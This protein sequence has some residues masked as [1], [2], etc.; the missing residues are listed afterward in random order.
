MGGR[1]LASFGPIAV[2]ASVALSAQT[3]QPAQTFRSGIDLIEVDVGVIDDDSRPIGDLQATDFSVSV[4][5]EPRRVVQAQF[6]SLRPPVRDDLPAES[7]AQ[8]A[9]YT[10]NTDAA[11]GRLIVIAVDEESIAFG[12]GR[13]VMRAAGAFVDSLGP[14]DR[15]ALLAVPQPGVYIDF[16]SNHARVRQAVD[17]MAGLG[18]PPQVT[19]NIS[20]FEAYRIAEYNDG[21]VEN[22]VV[23]RVCSAGFEGLVCR[24]RMQAESRQIVQE[25]RRRADNTRR[26]VESILGAMREVEGPKALVWISGGFVIDNGSTSL[27]ELEALAAESR[28]TLYVFML[29]E[30]LIDMSQRELAPTPRQDRRMKEEG[31]LAAAAFTGGSLVRAHYNPGPLFERLE[32]EL[33]GYYLL[34]VES[35]AGDRDGE[36]H[37][38]DVAVRRDGARVRARRSIRVTQET[39]A[40]SDGERLMDM[41]RSPVASRELPLR[42]AT[43]AYRGAGRSGMR[44]LVGA[45]VGVPGGVPSALTLGY[46]LRD[47]DGESAWSENMQVTP[48]LVPTPGGPVQEI[49]F[50]I[51]IETPGTFSLKLAV[52]DA[53]GR[54]GSVEHPVR[55]EHGP[56]AALDIGDLLVADQGS[57][58][59]GGILPPVEARVSGGRLLAY[60]E[61]YADSPAAW[62]RT[63][64]RIDVVDDEAGPALARGAAAIQGTGDALRG[65]VTGVAGVAHLPPGRY[66][67][68]ARVMRDAVEVARVRRPFRIVGP[69]DR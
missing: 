66:V 41:L 26:E 16:T 8:D 50:P 31:L 51:A 46:L 52:I 58:P 24:Y 21:G 48:R 12:E 47:P 30:P 25:T 6:V 23:A 9:F 14:A 17:G 39:A 32:E 35:R 29:D 2:A 7:A 18:T 37:A 20:L 34:G 68:R 62:E 27:R 49:S 1:R 54:R 11:R 63:E 55:A 56:Q 45:E 69:P 5:G 61:L 67:A 15:V 59:A 42:I 4:G 33:S 38:I 65:S 28:T 19:F 10:S 36:S 53:Q 40:S 22:E 57:S 3:S 44:I 60:T 43:Y 13:H 64:V